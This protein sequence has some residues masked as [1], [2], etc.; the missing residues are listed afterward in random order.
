LGCEGD[1]RAGTILALVQ[2]LQRAF[3]VKT[4]PLGNNFHELFCEGITTVLLVNTTLLELTLRMRPQEGGRWL[5]PLF[6]AMAIKTS[7]KSLDV[8][9]L[10]LADELA[11]GALRDA[12]AQNSVL[13]S[14]ALS[15]A[16][17][18]DTSV[19]SW[20]MTLSLHSGL[21]SSHLQSPSLDLCF[22]L[23]YPL[24][25]SIRYPC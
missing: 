18:C 15:L 2:A 12:L 16:A 24:F 19:V 22:G 13:E 9:D 11:C 14:L 4:L 7:L 21:V 8:N 17:L 3:F 23:I 20:R 6:V 25:V 5:Q 10:D 1:D